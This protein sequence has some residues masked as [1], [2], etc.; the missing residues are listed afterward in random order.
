MKSESA[1]HIYGSDA[2]IVRLGHVN[3]VH[4]DQPSEETIR[5]RTEEVMREELTGDA[6]FDD[7][8]LCQEMKKHPYNIVYDPEDEKDG[9]G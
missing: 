7:C 9:K 4:L 3:I 6:F 1:E 5:E 2:I 8:P